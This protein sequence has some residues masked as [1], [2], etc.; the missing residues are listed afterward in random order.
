MHSGLLFTCNPYVTLSVVGFISWFGLYVLMFVI[1]CDWLLVTDG[2]LLCSLCVT[3]VVVIVDCDFG[4]L[5]DLI[6]VGF[7]LVCLY[8]GL[9]CLC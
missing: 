3:L 5:L 1:V 7:R 6:V 8:T 4:G 9:T 2:W